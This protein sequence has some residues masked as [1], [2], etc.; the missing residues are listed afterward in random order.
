MFTGSFT[1]IICILIKD[2]NTN[3]IN[4]LVAVDNQY[5]SD[6]PELPNLHYLETGLDKVNSLVLDSLLNNDVYYK[7]VQTN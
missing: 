7:I 1:K 2:I 5:N 4:A 3:G 6:L